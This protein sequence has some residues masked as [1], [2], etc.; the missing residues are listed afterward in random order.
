M[1]PRSSG[2]FDCGIGVA[3]APNTPWGWEPADDSEIA[4]EV[5]VCNKLSAS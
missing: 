2:I 3:G 5:G 1:S 4:E